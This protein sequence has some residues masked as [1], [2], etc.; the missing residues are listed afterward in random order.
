MK[1]AAVNKSKLIADTLREES[2]SGSF[3][4][5]RFPSEAKVCRRFGVAR[6]TAVRA[7]ESLVREGLVVRRRG[8]GSFVA[9]PRTTCS[10]RAGSSSATSSGTRRTAAGSGR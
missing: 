6:Q 4:N 3:P 5:G 9:Q 8:A 1:D 7:I 2:V 10:S